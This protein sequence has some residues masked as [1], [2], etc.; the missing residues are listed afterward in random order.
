VRE[1]SRC[2]AT[3]RQQ[4][5]KGSGVGFGFGDGDGLLVEGT[6]EDLESGAYE[7]RVVQAAVETDALEVA[8]GEGAVDGVV[9]ADQ[10]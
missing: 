6:A 3:E 10:E 7:T 1:G 5:Q 8:L 2:G 4:K 9:D